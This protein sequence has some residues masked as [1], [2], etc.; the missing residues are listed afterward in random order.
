MEKL[1]HIKK[2]N[3]LS[4]DIKVGQTLEFNKNKLNNFRYFQKDYSGCY[5]SKTEEIDGKII[6]HYEDITTLLKYEDLKKKSEEEIKRILAILEAFHSCT[7]MEKREMILE[8]VRREKYTDKPSRYNCMWLTDEECISNW[9]K[10]LNAHEGNYSINEMELDG[11]IFVSTD[12]LLPVTIHKTED[13]Y[14]E[15]HKYWNPTQEQLDVS[16]KREYL[17]EGIAKVK[18]KIK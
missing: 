3:D 15:A 11:N 17:F 2:F 12:E 7:C 9:V 4:E 1:Y 6:N 5:C 8:E 13:M 14:D 18:R 10:L 16:K